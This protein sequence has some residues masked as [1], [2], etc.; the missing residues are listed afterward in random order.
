MGK[1]NTG[2]IGCG[3]IF[4]VH[5]AAVQQVTGARLAAVTDIDET[6]AKAASH[7]YSCNS[8]TDYQEMLLDEQIQVIHICTPHYLHAEMAIA[9]LRSG[10]HVL[11][12]K[13]MA[14]TLA[15]AAAMTATARETGKSLGVCF[16]NRYNSTAIRLKSILDSGQAGR[17]V[18]AKA[19]LKWHR[20]AAYYQNS[21]WRG[22]W[23]TE[24]GG[25]LINQAIHTL[26]LL[27]WFLG[28]IQS[29]AGS[30][31]TNGLKNII[32][33]ED[34]ARAVF[35]FSNGATADFF[36]TT[37][38]P[39]DAPVELE[40]ECERL[41]LKLAEDLTIQTRD[42]REERVAEVNIR[43]GA[44]AY[45]GCSH[46]ALITDFYRCL[47][48]GVRFPLDGTAGRA[49]LHMVRAIYA[50]A[51]QQREVGWDEVIAALL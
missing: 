18:H 33:V 43:T 5:A 48:T 25:V 30:V 23:A 1:L 31:A 50:S 11:V 44:K 36:A 14:I 45:W 10:K 8:Y 2:I 3:T 38:H 37:C 20:D 29:V 22:K 46:L 42:G 34:T 13:P 24:G 32:E 12:E 40:I 47:Q 7:Q 6:K 19:T 21:G 16:Q 26:D 17:V 27:Q 41:T 28:D 4:G 39:V 35:T 15:D 51:K 9:A 49:A